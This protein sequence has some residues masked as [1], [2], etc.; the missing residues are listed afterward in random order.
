MSKYSTYT[1]KKGTELPMMSLKGKP[2]MQ[3]AHRLI[4]FTEEVP[5]YSTTT[6]FISI[7]EEY[8]VAKVT[9]TIWEKNAA[10]YQQASKSAT[11]TKREDKKSFADHTE[12]AETGA[13]GR[14]LALLGYGTQYAVADLDEGDRLA[15]SP[16]ATADV[17]QQWNK[18]VVSDI[19]NTPNNLVTNNNVL[20]GPAGSGVTKAP[21]F[22][23]PKT[24]KAPDKDLI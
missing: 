1:T 5:S 8:T 20:G 12:K 15:D 24:N 10:G 19:I 14:C 7:T 11:A 22:K 4:W 9:V 6:E 2:Y 23:V 16:V 13:L 18:S 21:S 3:V 17:K